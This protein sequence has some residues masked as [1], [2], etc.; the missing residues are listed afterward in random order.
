MMFQG[1]V[2]IYHKGVWGGICDDEWDNLEATIAC[3][4]LGFSDALAATHGSRYG[5]TPAN[6]WMDS[7]YCYGT[8]KSL[9]VMSQFLYNIC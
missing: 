4:T 6:I 3:K 9:Q 2:E 8:E 7:L 5:N 1:N